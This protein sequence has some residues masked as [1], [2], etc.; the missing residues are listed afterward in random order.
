MTTLYVR[1]RDLIRRFG[2][3]PLVWGAGGDSLAVH[4]A[5][6]PLLV[7]YTQ[8]DMEAKGLRKLDDPTAP[9]P[10]VHFTALDMVSRERGCLLSG[11]TG[12]GKTSFSLDLALNLAGELVGDR[13]YGLK[14]LTRM[15][16]R[17][18]AGT[19]RQES[20][21]GPVPEPVLYRVEDGDDW[22]HVIRTLTDE[23]LLEAN[24]LLI[25]DGLEKCPDPES[26]LRN[27]AALL[28]AHSALRVVVLADGYF[29]RGLAVP[30][31][32]APFSLIALNDAQ[33]ADALARR[34][35]RADADG[36]PARPDLFVAA[37]AVGGAAG[38]DPVAVADAWLHAQSDER[39]AALATA[40]VADGQPVGA[41]RLITSDFARTILYPVLAARAFSMLPAH[42]V[43]VRVAQS[44]L[45]WRSTIPL[46][47]MVLRE[48]G[49]G[50]TA[51]ARGL[52]ELSD[53]WAIG[54]L[55]AAALCVTSTDDDDLLRA[56]RRALTTMIAQGGATLALR[57][58]AARYL[59]L[60][61]DPRALDTL[62]DVPPGRSVIGSDTHPNSQPVHAVR[63]AGYRIGR[64]P[65][66]VAAY[67]AFV[68][69]TGRAWTSPDAARAERANAPATDVTWYDACA[70]CA[71]LTQRWRAEGRIAADEVVRL[72]TEM[73]WERAARGDHPD[74]SGAVVYP[75][76]GAWRAG[77][78]NSAELGLNTPVAVGLCAYGR[79]PYGADDMAG[80]IWEWTTT[81]W[82]PDMATPDFAYPYR[83]D[84]REAPDADVSI[85]RVLRGGCFSS[86]R[87]KACCTYRGSLEPNGFWRGNG[88][89]VVVSSADPRA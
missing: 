16:A 60:V 78:S 18:G 8:E 59:A 89:R 72:P 62:I 40:A 75:W 86:N 14:A 30:D 68:R 63:L 71:W 74:E 5:Y 73:E 26:I 88:F 61:G 45:R 27:A 54:L 6:I 25:I 52:L 21:S 23:G 22:D 65:V 7:S 46:L 10:P 82:G 42:D 19:R 11:D 43:L 53:R 56:A 35:C 85:R 55:S 1:G 36:M 58:Q 81:L 13:R 29:C 39:R 77:W 66:T 64:Y 67:G 38:A 48:R 20:W 87:L 44:P 79:S 33:K 4:Q 83:D 9:R 51:L 70:Y 32:F 49:Q 15:V 17:N 3:A 24:T 47:A 34:A 57:D 2:D 50:T 76:V 69:E 12:S 84:G 31:A 37:M 80:N 41:D 28:E